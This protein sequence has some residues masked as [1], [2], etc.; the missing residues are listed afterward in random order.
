MCLVNSNIDE[1]FAG[2]LRP[3]MCSLSF[4]FS[5]YNYLRGSV[6]FSVKHIFMSLPSFSLASWHIFYVCTTVHEQHDGMYGAALQLKW[7]RLSINEQHF[8]RF[9]IE[10][11]QGPT[12][13]TAGGFKPLNM[14]AL[15]QV[16][17]SFINL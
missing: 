10:R 8:Y 1:L 16:L 11:C 12:M 17:F 2:K 4:E 9:Y 6:G 7:Y 3:I 5:E 13:L 14:E 15:V